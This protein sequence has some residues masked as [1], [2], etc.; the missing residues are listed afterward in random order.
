MRSLGGR[1]GL[2]AKKVTD[3]VWSMSDNARDTEGV[4][5]KDGMFVVAAAPP[6]VGL[7]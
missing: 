5:Q 7:G 1:I 2:D 4:Y 6:V 3:P